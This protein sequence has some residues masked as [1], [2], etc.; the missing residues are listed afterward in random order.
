VG[1]E[2]NPKSMRIIFADDHALVRQTLKTMLKKLSAGESVDVDEADSL[3]SALNYSGTPPKPSMVI[4]D[5]SMPGMRGP[6]DIVLVKEAFPQTPI[7]VLSGYSERTTI[8]SCFQNGAAGFLPKSSS[9]EEFIAGLNLV[10]Q[11]QRYV[12]TLLLNEALN[13][14]ELWTERSTK[15]SPDPAL[16]K[17]LSD[18][19]KRML[20]LMSQGKS[21][22]EI[23][24]DLCV[25]E[26][27]VKFALR[28]LYR[29]IGANNRASAVQIANKAG[30]V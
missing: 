10:L 2:G 13:L 23:G 1:L 28:R 8:L 21:N 7:V 14:P 9:S 16:A 12:P 29:T 17:L 24:R 30:L 18:R 27:T 3:E 11:G 15:P 25:E 6:E 5:L 4:L 26:V 19:E 22:K 20:V